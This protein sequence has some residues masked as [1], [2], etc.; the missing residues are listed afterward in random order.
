MLCTVAAWAFFMLFLWRLAAGFGE[1]VLAQESL[2]I[3]AVG[4]GV[5]AGWA[6]IIALISFLGPLAQRLQGVEYGSVVLLMLA[7]PVLGLLGVIWLLWRVLD[8]IGSVRHVILSKAES[9]DVSRAS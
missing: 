6:V 9:E 5:T 3:L 7:L 4:L 8:L 1:R 2:S